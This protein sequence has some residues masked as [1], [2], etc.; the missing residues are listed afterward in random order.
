MRGKT[1]MAVAL[2]LQLF[3]VAPA[4]AATGGTQTATVLVDGK[5]AALQKQAILQQQKTYV[6]AADAA[7][8]LQAAWTLDGQKG[9]L[10]LGERTIVFQLD[11]GTVT[12]DGKPVAGGE[13]AL[14]RGKEVYVPL[15]WLVEQAG[16]EIAWN[17]EKKAVEI[18]SKA[19][20]DAFVLV[21]EKQLSKE[22]QDFI[23][24][25]KGKRGVHQRGDLYVIA[26][27]QA[28][29]PGYGLQ[30][31]KVEQKW[32]QLFVYV[33]QSEP[34]PGM[35]YPQVIAYPYLTAKVKLPPYTTISFI[36]ADTNKPLF[37]GQAQG[38]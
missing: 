5:A 37:E 1:W 15:R 8:L 31:T 33:K 32:E 7:S 24:S 17:A 9:Q 23:E 18:V 29:H 27:G 25:V 34:A 6:S 2:S 22:E 10:K 21:D 4:L 13:A 38:Q 11:A 16:H 36:D 20:N 12:V 3:A 35:M 19:Q 14:V 30:V 28:P 26:R